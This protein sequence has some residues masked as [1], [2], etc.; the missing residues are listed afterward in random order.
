MGI[1]C[2]TSECQ[3]WCLVRESYSN[4]SRHLLTA[5]YIQVTVAETGDDNVTVREPFRQLCL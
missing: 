1:K 2:N 3:L 4:W 5:M